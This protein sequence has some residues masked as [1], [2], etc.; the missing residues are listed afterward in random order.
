MKMEVNMI[1]RIISYF[2]VIS[3][4][5][6][7]LGCSSE[8]HEKVKIGLLMSSLN[9][10]YF[11]SLKAGAELEAKKEGYSLLVSNSQNDANR[12][13]PR[14]KKLI[15]KGIKVL[16]LNAVSIKSST[17]VINYANKHNVKVIAIDR[18]LPDHDVIA[19][20]SSDNYRGGELAGEYIKQRLRG[21][22]IILDMRG[23][24]NTV[25]TQDRTNGLLS[26]IKGT[27]LKVLFSKDAGE[28]Q[29]KGIAIVK[30]ELQSNPEISAIFAHNDQIALGVAYYL[31][32]HH[33]GNITVIGFDGTH[34]AMMAI[35]SGKI[36]ATIKQKPHKM[37]ELGVK[38]AIDVL[39]GKKVSRSIVVPVHIITTNMLAIAS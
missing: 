3:F 14:A 23:A 17:A 6:L 9:N 29:I 12:E 27:N 8:H 31:Q 1:K 20:I 11:T 24:P 34:E 16:L 18:A 32:K 37:G 19:N 2:I 36:S 33:K 26:A 13:L 5:F 39:N 7:L 15:G 35:Q 30:E 10:P 25:V 38:A 21:S 4:F 22:G 28:N